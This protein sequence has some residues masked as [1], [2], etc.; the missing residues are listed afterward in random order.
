MT[1]DYDG[2]LGP[3]CVCEAPAE[4]GMFSIVLLNQKAPIPGRGW[5]CVVCQLPSDGAIAV[6]CNRC[7]DDADEGQPTA[8]RFACRGY[9]QTDGRVPID[10]LTGSQAHDMRRHA[11]D[12][13]L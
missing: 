3:C 9:P 1:A 4:I 7:L 6:V 10:T 11:E 8:L 2:T 13:A 5:G 12:D